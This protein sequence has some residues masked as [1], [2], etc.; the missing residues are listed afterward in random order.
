MVMLKRSLAGTLD[1]WLS[2]AS[3]LEKYGVPSE[4]IVLCERGTRNASAPNGITL[5]LPLALEAKR[6]SN[7]KV[8]VD[9][10][11]GTKER[12]HVL[13]MLKAIL[14]MDFD[15]WMIEVHPKPRE[16]WS[17]AAQAISLE[18]FSHFMADYFPHRKILPP[19]LP[20]L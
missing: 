4:K 2:A 17:D 7:Y 3:Y 19:E 18:E 15:G 14:A 6:T 11:H 20:T 8:I 13:A 5:D 10:S 16:S 9:P 12:T 1:E